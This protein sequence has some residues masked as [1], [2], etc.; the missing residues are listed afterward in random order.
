MTVIS[1]EQ[2]GSIMEGPVTD[3]DGVM[4][5]FGDRTVAIG[6]DASETPLYDL[7]LSTWSIEPGTILAL[8]PR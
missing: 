6:L 7:T 3:R 1:R 5:Y 8:E 4:G 2:Q